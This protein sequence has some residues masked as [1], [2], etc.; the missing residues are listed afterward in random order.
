M[1]GAPT[2]P[3]GGSSGERG[4]VNKSKGKRLRSG[5][6]CSVQGGWLCCR[7]AQASWHH[8]WLHCC[9]DCRYWSLPSGRPPGTSTAM[10]LPLS[11][12]WS[13]WVACGDLVW[14]S[15]LLWGMA[16]AA[17]QQRGCI[18][19][20]ASGRPAV[21]GTAGALQPSLPST[22]AAAPQPTMPGSCSIRTVPAVRAHD[23]KQPLPNQQHERIGTLASKLVGWR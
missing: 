20:T 4:A 12:I 18:R 16:L 17:D 23:T 5:G 9:M 21:C 3:T 14:S 7:S 19:G 13:R 10:L 22:S 1:Q 15:D 11:R 8:G 2:E 6:Q